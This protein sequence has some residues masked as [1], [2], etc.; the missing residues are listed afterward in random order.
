M[1]VYVNGALVAA[2]EARVDPADRGFTLGDGLF[3]TIAVAGGAPRRLAAHL[4]RLERGAHVLDLKLPWPLA[5][6]GRAVAETIVANG[7]QEGVLRLTVTRGPALRGL[8]PPALAH[9]TLVIAPAPWPQAPAPARAVIATETRR[10]ERSPLSRIKCLG[11]LDNVLARK[12]AASRG[13]DDAL[14]LNTLGRI[15]EATASNVFLV[16]DGRLVTP[17][18]D[19]GALPGVMRADV[20]AQLSAA[21]RSLTAE[22]LARASEAFLTNSLGVRALVAVNGRPIGAGAPGPIAARARAVADG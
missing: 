12:E 8:L 13:A 1:K 6:L 5:D 21:E 10:N 11:C 18:V 16:L 9:P 7:L 17:P 20:I 14:L 22:D 3:E 19:D 4:A 15:A 2:T